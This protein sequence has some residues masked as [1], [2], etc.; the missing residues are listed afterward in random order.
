MNVGVGVIGA[1]TVGGGVID[2]LLDNSGVI[3][4]KTGAQVTLKHV[5]ELRGELLKDFVL[6]GVRVSA[7]AADLIA[8]PEVNVV[9]ELIGR[10]RGGAQTD[11]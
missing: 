7:D 3:E 1:G 2:I 5:A 8:D 6:D 11:S 4:D 10:R 9:C